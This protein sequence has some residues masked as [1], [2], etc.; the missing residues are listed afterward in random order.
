VT[1][2]LCE[3]FTSERLA[4]LTAA[5]LLVNLAIACSFD[6]SG[7]ARDASGGDGVDE[8]SGVDPIDA[9]PPD[10]DACVGWTLPGDLDSCDIPMDKRDDAL[11]L[12]GGTYTYNTV[13]GLLSPPTGPV[14][15]LNEQHVHDFGALRVVSAA[16]IEIQADATLRATGSAPLILAAWSD[17]TVAGEIDVS[18]RRNPASAGAGADPTECMNVNVAAG[19]GRPDSSGGGG[20]GG[21]GHAAGGGN[22]GGGNG[23]SD[24]AGEAGR[25]SGPAIRLRG[26]CRGGN[27]G[28]GDDE[29]SPS[30]PGG[31]G[32]G[33][34]A[35]SARLAL[36][37]DGPIHAGGA[38]GTGGTRPSGGAGGGGAGGLIWLAGETIRLNNTAVL[39]ANG[40]GG[41]EGGDNGDPGGPGDD[42]QSEGTPARGGTTG[43]SNGGGGGN[44]NDGFSAGSPGI[45]G[46]SNSGGGGGGGG[47]GIIT[48][49]APDAA[50]INNAQTISPGLSARP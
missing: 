35:L 6:G 2:R 13:T 40:G 30:I 43:P 28:E 11:V 22:G 32:G 31:A 10:A 25:S 39:A 44:G 46:P 14:I 45:V 12:E 4:A 19:D 9:P 18:S 42:A 29:G 37:V 1:L 24:G 8:D 36:V 17:L 50:I 47:P 15:D 3:R 41:G 27:G 16:T 33:A 38:G 23:S 49:D 21:G 26:G 48:L 7:T 5:T 34:V 20:G